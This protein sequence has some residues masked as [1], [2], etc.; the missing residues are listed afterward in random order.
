MQNPKSQSFY[1]QGTK[2][3][4]GD[5]YGNSQCSNAHLLFAYAAGTGNAE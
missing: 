5:T 2:N 1:R 4:R 3:L